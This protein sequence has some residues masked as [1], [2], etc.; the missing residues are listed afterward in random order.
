MTK[1][2]FTKEILIQAIWADDFFVVRDALCGRPD[3]E[4]SI[5]DEDHRTCLLFAIK[6]G[7]QQVIEQLLKMEIPLNHQDS[8]GQTALMYAVL[9]LDLPLCRKL[10]DLDCEIRVKNQDGLTALELAQQ[11]QKEIITQSTVNAVD[12]QRI[13]QIITFLLRAQEERLRQEKKQQGPRPQIFRSPLSD[14]VILNLQK[15]EDPFFGEDDEGYLSFSEDDEEDSEEEQVSNQHQALYDKV[16]EGI[17][18]EKKK[19]K[20]HKRP[21]ALVIR[22]E[23][24]GENANK[25]AAIGDRHRGEMLVGHFQ[26]DEISGPQSYQL[27]KNELKEAQS[28]AW[29]NR[30]RPWNGS[31]DYV[32]RNNLTPEQ[33]ECLI[34]FFEVVRGQKSQFKINNKLGQKSVEESTRKMAESKNSDPLFSL[35]QNGGTGAVEYIMNA[36][37]SVNNMDKDGNTPLIF[38]VQNNH[39]D[40]VEALLKSGART[41]LMNN[42]GHTALFYAV[43]ENNLKIVNLLLEKG[44]NQRIRYKGQS[45]LMLAASHGLFEMVKILLLIGADPF[46]QDYNGRRA[47]DH[48]LTGG[49]KKMYRFLQM[50]E[51][52][53]KRRVA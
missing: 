40:I 22:G 21:S 24:N 28:Y 51:R 14:E 52:D 37:G 20:T 31:P 1:K 6:H 4:L 13:Q 46:V 12:H 43:M 50:V 33:K 30:L 42:F 10:L 35:G 34:E 25:K 16:M 44:A 18:G 29:K 48:A 26:R 38:A 27:K 32:F 11:V 49:H 41:N 7:S 17:E 8:Y 15:E 9:S 23:E 3:L 2:T 47:K 53:I 36:G 45:I 39:Y 5:L 19:K